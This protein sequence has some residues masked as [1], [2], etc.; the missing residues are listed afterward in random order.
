MESSTPPSTRSPSGNTGGFLRSNLWLLGLGLTALIV[1]I[2][3]L[4]K[5]DYIVTLIIVVLIVAMWILILKLPKWV[6]IAIVI[7]F[8]IFSW[9]LFQPSITILGYGADGKVVA[10]YDGSLETEDCN[11]ITEIVGMPDVY[12]IVSDG[13]NFRLVRSTRN[14]CGQEVHSFSNEGTGEVET[15]PIA[16]GQNLNFR[17]YHV[18]GSTVTIWWRSY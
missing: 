7:A 10:E 17:F 4:W 18:L 5:P 12:A 15:V 2:W 11:C 14:I 13:Q 16:N 3:F 1:T 8:L 9:M 6:G